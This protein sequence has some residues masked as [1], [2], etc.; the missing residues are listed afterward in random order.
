MGTRKDGF[1]GVFAGAAGAVR[2]LTLPVLFATAG[3]PVRLWLEPPAASPPAAYLRPV[4][5]GER[6]TR[7]EI[8]LIDGFNV[9]SVGLLRGEDRRAWWRARQRD[10]LLARAARFDDPAAELWVVFDG[11]TSEGDRL[12]GPGPRTVFAPSA[13]DWLV[14]RLRSEEDPARVAVVTADRRLAG[15]VRHH[16]GRVVTPGEFL[17]RCPG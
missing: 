9:V 12:D 11:A 13:D 3:L 17:S 8:W 14:R 15:R 16:G 2:A 1:V 10:A 4:Q 7:G 5:E 6:E